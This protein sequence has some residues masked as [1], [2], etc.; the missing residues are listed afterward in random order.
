MVMWIHDWR[1]ATLVFQRSDAAGAEVVWRAGLRWARFVVSKHKWRHDKA[2]AA[3]AFDPLAEMGWTGQQRYWVW[4]LIAGHR[5]KFPALGEVKLPG[6]SETKLHGF[7]E[8]QRAQEAL[9]QRLTSEL[10]FSSAGEVAPEA[11]PDRALQ[12]Q[13]SGFL[14]MADWIASDVRH[15]L[16]NDDLAAVGT[17]QARAR[18]AAEWADLGLWQGWGGCCGRLRAAF[19]ARSRDSQRA[20]LRCA[21]RMPHPG[22]MSRADSE[23]GG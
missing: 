5:G 22:L 6:R 7:V 2:G 23:G 4:P 21:A 19:G 15:F 13:L 8:W 18:A 17:E 9:V 12:L 14:V 3:V 16:G 11:A 1:K 20:T 10:G